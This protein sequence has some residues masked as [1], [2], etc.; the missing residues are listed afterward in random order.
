MVAHELCVQKLRRVGSDK[1]VCKQGLAFRA[2]IL[3]VK[4]SRSFFSLLRLFAGEITR[5]SFI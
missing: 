2:S 4:N 1:V 5:E 3:L